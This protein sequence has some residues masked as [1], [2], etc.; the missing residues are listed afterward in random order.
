MCVCVCVFVTKKRKCI[1]SQ[2]E[3]YQLASLSSSSPPRCAMYIPVGDDGRFHEG[4]TDAC[5]PLLP[6]I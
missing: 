4:R 6:S 3:K 5:S 1:Y 2:S